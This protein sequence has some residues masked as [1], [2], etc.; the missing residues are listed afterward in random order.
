[1]E[2]RTA[3]ALKRYAPDCEYVDTSATIYDYNQAIASH[4]TGESDLVVIEDDKEITAGVLPSFAKCDSYWCSYSYFVFPKMIG[5]EVEIGLGCTR[6]SARLQQLVN[7]E[8]FLCEDPTLVFHTVCDICHGKGCWKYLDARIADAIRG[9]GINV[10]CHGQI[11]HNHRYA[12][13]LLEDGLHIAQAQQNRAKEFCDNPAKQKLA[14]E[15]A[16]PTW[17]G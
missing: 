7:P 16:G 12:S 1:M 5:H 3:K 14:L 2:E 8:E 11:K 15:L 13:V 4:W 17:Q 6:F 10:H 9:H